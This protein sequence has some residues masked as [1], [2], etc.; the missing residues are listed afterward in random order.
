MNEAPTKMNVR[1]IPISKIYI[2]DEFNCRGTLTPLDVESLAKD[3]KEN[4]LHQPVVV[5]SSEREGYDYDLIAGFRRT[6]AHKILNLPMIPANIKDKMSQKDA[7]IINLAENVKRQDLDLM[8]EA[9]ALANLK[10][11]GMTQEA[12]GT[13]LGQSRGWVQ[14]RYALLELPA[15]IQEE[16]AAGTITQYHVKKIAGLPRHEDMYEAVKKIKRAKATGEKIDHTTMR[17]KPNKHAKKDRTKKDVKDLL[18]H[19]VDNLGTT[20]ATKVLAWVIGEQTDEQLFD[21]LEQYHET[22]IK[23]PEWYD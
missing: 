5:K 21:Y 19:L 14:V 15:P 16:A 1:D 4:G 18:H 20:P 23:R 17:K 11:L 9:K 13:E 10:R 3:I 2:D 22:D 12:V 6:Y 7:L 8:Q